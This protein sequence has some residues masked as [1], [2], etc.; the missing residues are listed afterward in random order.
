VH[1]HEG[2]ASGSAVHICDLQE[3]LSEWVCHID[4]ATPKIKIKSAQITRI[5]D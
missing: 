5:E 2:S 3:G 4:E 1:L